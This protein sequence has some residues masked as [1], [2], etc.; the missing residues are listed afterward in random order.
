MIM[1]RLK[2][3]IIAM[4][5]CMAAQAMPRT[6]FASDIKKIEQD[7]VRITSSID[8]TKKRI[9]SSQE[10][11]FLPDL[12][13]MLGE[14][15]V[16]KARLSYS[17][18]RE[19]NSG[20]PAEELDFAPEKQIRLEAIE[21]YKLIEERYPR[22]ASLDKVIFIQGQELLQLKDTDQA[23]KTFK[24]ITD[25]FP[26]SS[27][28]PRAMIEIGNIFFDKKDYDFALEQYKKVMSLSVA[29]QKLEVAYYKAALCYIHKD[30]FLNS[31]L[32]FDKV[33]SL[34]K[35]NKVES[36]DDIREE[37]LIASV[38]PISELTSENVGTHKKFLDP[39]KYYQS[40][41]FDKAVFRRV[42]NRFGKRMVVKVRHKEAHLA[43]LELFRLSDDV[44]ER[45]EAMENFYLRGKD[46][47]VEYYPSW[48]AEE[49]AKTLW[50]VKQE[51][52]GKE[53]KKQE[54]PKYEAFFRD[55]TT[56]LHKNAMVTKRQ[57]DLRD[58][59]K[60]YD[61]YLWIYPKSEFASDIS[62][63]MAEASFHSKDFIKGGEYYNQAAQLTKK[64][65]KRQDYLES[66]IQS[67]TQ[68]FAQAEKLNPVEKIQGRAGFQKLATLFAKEYPTDPGLPAVQ[69]NFAKSYY[70][71]QNFSKA[72]DQFRSFIKTYPKSELVEQAAVLLVDSFY[73][74]DDL[75]GVVREG[76]ALQKNN[77]LPQALRSKMNQVVSQ[78]QL[79]KVR[80]IAGEMGSK[81]YADKFLEFAKSAKDSNMSESAL[82][83]AFAALKA[84]NDPRVFEIGE[85][86]LGRYGT[87]PRGKEVL[88]SLSQKAL[89][90]ADYRRAVKYLLAFGQRHKNDPAAKEAVTQAA[91]LSDQLGDSSEAVQAYSMSGDDKKSAAIYAR[92]TQWDSLAKLATSLPGV[93]GLYYQGLGIYR[94]GQQ[95]EGLS[96][97]KR[98]SDS[99]ASTDEEKMIVAHAGIIVAETDIE[100]FREIGKGETF[101][102]PLLQRKIQAYQAIDSELQKIIGSGAGKW[103][104]AALM[105]YAKLNQDFSEFLKASQPPQGMNAAQFQQMIRPQIEKYAGTANENY[106]KCMAAAEEFE[107]FTQYVNG[108]ISRGQV[109][110]KESMDSFPRM[111]ANGNQSNDWSAIRSDL[112]KT[113]RSIPVLRKAMSLALRDSDYSYAQVIV[114]RMIEIDPQ[115]SQ[116][117]ADLG[118]C[119]LFM[120]ELD[121]AQSS[122]TEA[123]KKDA[124]NS[125]AL[126]ALTGLYKKYSF[127]KKYSATF[128]KAKSA[129]KPLEPIHPLMKL[130]AGL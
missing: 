68:G 5:L 61:K 41:S 115:S 8:L 35:K 26:K 2:V 126:W 100:N 75:Q 51:D 72:A 125:S 94:K 103:V 120:N 29:H 10:I 50:I 56:T 114:E 47:K 12:Y 25:R 78:A 63:N 130:G 88:L 96:L 87:N 113:P 13:F 37:A 34:M 104:I 93:T 99:S 17:L 3:L 54:L 27:Y 107:V 11:E 102:V 81:D 44:K 69:F 97:L 43:F 122:F 40:V 46:A 52:L 9:K 48:V 66:A 23:L 70:D 20:A 123:L 67:Y 92:A 108:C 89:I 6:A 86:Y 111:K 21:T 19:R 31:M 32:H 39:L 85:Q 109:N 53:L 16:D 129:G 30:E 55:F 124:K 65:N 95:K 73:V 90:S 116:A 28:Y 1:R 118:V 84:G 71:E 91:L 14:L 57:E 79:K 117:Y 22:F 18:K 38:W 80:S 7:L 105:N 24:K 106:V 45:K 62:L 82:Y 83:E 64:K 36:A 119:Q 60:A 110:V 74:R 15:L 58:V 49:I 77:S 127:T 98:T 4:S 101:S 59:V 112:V 128:A 76:E 33:F 42:L 121:A